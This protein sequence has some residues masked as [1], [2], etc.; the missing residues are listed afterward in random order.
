MAAEAGLCTIP[1]A[2]DHMASGKNQHGLCVVSL[3]Y[4]QAVFLS[5]LLVS[6]ILSVYVRETYIPAHPR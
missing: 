2:T 1:M 6:Y 4:E 5:L 3:W